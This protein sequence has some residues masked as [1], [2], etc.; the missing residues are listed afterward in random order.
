MERTADL[1]CMGDQRGTKTSGSAQD[2][3]DWACMVL[4]LDNTALET[5]KILGAFL[6]QQLM[7]PQK[8]FGYPKTARKD[9]YNQLTSIPPI[10][11]VGDSGNPIEQNQ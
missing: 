6:S 11:F 1:E 2:R 7:E 10:G 5:A 9:P 8:V 4:W 3:H